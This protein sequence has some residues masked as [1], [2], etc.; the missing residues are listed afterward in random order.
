MLMMKTKAD[1]RGK[2]MFVSGG[3]GL[4]GSRVA[5]RLCEAG[6]N[7]RILSRSNT[8]DRTASIQMIKGDI[9]EKDVVEKAIS[10]CYG[11][12]HCAA[13]LRDAR[14]MTD[15][16][17]L[18][19]E[20]IYN[21]VRKNKAKFF[22][23]I[24]SVG[25]IGRTE[26]IEVNEET[27]CNPMNRYEVTKLEAEQIVEQGVENCSTII[28]RPTNIFSGQS[29]DSA[30]QSSALKLLKTL[31]KGKEYAHLVY[32]EDV[33]AAAVY[34]LENPIK[35]AFGK[36]IVSSDE[37]P[38]NT[39]GEIYNL[40]KRL[41]GSDNCNHRY[42]IPEIVPYLFRILKNGK[43]NRGNI[44]YSSKRL[45]ST[46]FQMPFGLRKG[47]RKAIEDYQKGQ[48]IRNIDCSKKLTS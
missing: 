9:C 24:S 35:I 37:E 1:V 23:H 30:C 36:F 16:N 33:A 8:R 48:E 19:T 40:T 28:L 20:N 32:V 15:V 7:V 13:E 22:C 4:L 14:K 5:Y 45:F 31:L 47:I 21:A 27:A 11:V 17:I 41:M 34:F 43:S 25:V 3:T 46:G 38:G 39:I 44:L 2:T 29:I 18:G 26:E 12:F 6:Y 10:E 42:F